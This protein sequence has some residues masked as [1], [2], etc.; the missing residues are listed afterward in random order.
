MEKS[1]KY[2]LGFMIGDK[3]CDVASSI[4]SGIWRITKY[5]V[6]ETTKMAVPMLITLAIAKKTGLM[7]DINVNVRNNVRVTTNAASGRRV[8]F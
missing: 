2:D 7:D 3:L 8:V 6:V 1:S 4:V 5:T